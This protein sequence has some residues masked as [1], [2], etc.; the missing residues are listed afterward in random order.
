MMTW[1]CAPATMGVHRFHQP[2]ATSSIGLESPDAEEKSSPTVSF[3]IVRRL[4]MGTLYPVQ[5]AR[6]NFTPE[7]VAAVVHHNFNLVFSMIDLVRHHV[8]TKED[9]LFVGLSYA[10]FEKDCQNVCE[11]NEQ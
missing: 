4:L 8:Y 1:V 10:G 6:K 5:F 7:D 11:K 2:F 9:V 3:E